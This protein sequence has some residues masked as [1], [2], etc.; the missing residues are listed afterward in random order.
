MK[1]SNLESVPNL[2]SHTVSQNALANAFRTIAQVIIVVIGNYL[3]VRRIS[4]VDYGLVILVTTYASFINLADIGISTALIRSIAQYGKDRNVFFWTAALFYGCI[5][6]T[7]TIALFAL[8]LILPTVFFQSYSP[9]LYLVSLI[10]L[11][12]LLSLLLSVL[13]NTLNGLQLMKRSSLVEVVKSLSFYILTLT[14][15]PSTGL[16]AFGYSTVFSNLIV[17]ALAWWLLTQRASIEWQRPQWSIVKTFFNFGGQTYVITV[18]SQLK[19]SGIKILASWFYPLSYVT[20]LELALRISSYVRQFLSS[21]TIPLLPAAALLQAQKKRRS[22]RTLIQ[23][24]LGFISATSVV[25]GGGLIIFMPWII[26]WWLG[27]EYETVV[28]LSRWAIVAVIAN[29]IAAPVF[30]VLHGLGEMKPLMITAALALI[31]YLVF[32]YG[33]AWLQIPDGLIMGHAL[34]EGVASVGFLGWVWIYRRR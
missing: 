23:T 30:T 9:S 17:M 15:L 27:P 34:A 2:L 32:P 14:L 22:L 1:F 3:I 7:I 29:M 6:G 25:G 8:Y 13:T 31:G 33:L 26:G 16:L 12:S 5:G 10:L 21:L 20:F 11:G 19:F 4:P 18:V 24:S 28:S